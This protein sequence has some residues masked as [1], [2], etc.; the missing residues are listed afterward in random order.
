[1]I[2]E[3]CIT[4]NLTEREIIL[5]SDKTH[6]EIGIKLPSEPGHKTYI[7][8]LAPELRNIRYDAQHCL[9]TAVHRLGLDVAEPD[10]QVRRKI[11][12]TQLQHR[13]ITASVQIQRIDYGDRG[14]Q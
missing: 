13:H 3:N 5:S 12:T 1:M 11:V 14:H 8:P 9:G 10:L 2:R 4:I 6:L 7:K